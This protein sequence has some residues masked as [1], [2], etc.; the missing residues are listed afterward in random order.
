MDKQQKNESIMPRR[1]PTADYIRYYLAPLLHVI[2]SY[3]ARVDCDGETVR[4]VWSNGKSRDIDI[5]GLEKQMIAWKVLKGI[6]V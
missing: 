1:L 2:D 6:S 3:I 5:T 4:V